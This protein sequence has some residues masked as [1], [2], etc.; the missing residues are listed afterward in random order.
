LDFLACSGGLKLIEAFTQIG[1][2]KLRRSLVRLAEELGGE[3][4]N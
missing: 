1:D 2:A 3:S 4:D